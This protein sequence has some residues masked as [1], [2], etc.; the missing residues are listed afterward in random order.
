M[1]LISILSLRAHL[2]SLALLLG[3]LVSPVTAQ[4]EPLRV[5]QSPDYQPLV[6]RHEGKVVGIEPDNA[7]EVAAILGRP[8]EIIEMPMTE[9]IPALESG[10]V[11]VVMSGFSITPERQAVVDF[12]DPFLRIGQMAIILVDNAARFAQPRALYRPGVRIGVEPRTTGESYV[13][14]QFPQATILNFDDPAGAFAALRAG[15]AD[16]Y[17]HDAP[18]SWGLAANTRENQDLLSLYRPLTSEALAWAV[19]KGNTRLQGQ[20]NA[21]LDK[22]RANGRLQAIQNYWIPVTVQVR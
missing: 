18:T 11:D 3:L 14:D 6:F 5:A 7:R 21:A 12:A 22:L 20:L 13:L 19:R 1:R 2:G 4:A 9:F 10:R 16:V 17:I 15:V 8:L